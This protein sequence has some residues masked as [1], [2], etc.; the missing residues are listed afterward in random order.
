MKILLVSAFPPSK[1]NL[2]VPSALPFYLAEFAPPGFQLDLVYYEGFEKFEYLFEDELKSV[3][4]NIT[5]VAK[6]AKLIY[7][8]LRLIQKLNLN[9]GL[10][11]TSL[12][13]IPNKK[14]LKQIQEAN[15]DIVWI[16]PH[17]LYSWFNNLKKTRVVVTGPDCSYL[18]YSL[19]AEIYKEGSPEFKGPMLTNHH[20]INIKEL[21]RN[22]YQIDKRW[23][24][25]NALIHVVGEDDLKMYKE[26]GALNHSF[27]SAHP[28]FE[29]T[30]IKKDILEE[31][32]KLKILITGVN[33]SIY[34]GNFLD[35]IIELLVSNKQ[36]CNYYQFQFLG[37]GF[38][39]NH[40]RLL[41]AGY[42]SKLSTWVDSYEDF[43]SE[44]NLQIFP[45][46]LGT[47]TKGKVL[48]ALSTGLLCIGTKYAFENI[49]ID[50]DMDCIL[51]DKEID[52]VTALEN[53][54]ADKVKYLKMAKQAEA[55]VR[56][57]H[58]PQVTAN[59]FWNNIS[60]YY[61]NAF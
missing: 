52:I 56:L 27:Y 22:A 59:E 28:F 46:I 25:S 23:S 33:H 61:Q 10:A 12:K 36:L 57:S 13:Y 21:K 8:P 43:I 7:Y 39:Q 60:N 17:T 50:I 31:D 29:F 24:Q 30:E 53:I 3:F 11:G 51:V 35:R 49:R 2:G 1:H 41:S 19:M 47:G 4:T 16:Y 9:K 40:E 5:K 37:K 32:G 54:I 14:Q 45:I 55:K 44:A 42:S 6:T 15:Y 18:H 34:I 20:V 38:E 26:L 58:S 48:S